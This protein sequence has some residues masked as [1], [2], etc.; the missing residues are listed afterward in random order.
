VIG[1]NLQLLEKDLPRDERIQRRMQ[2][3]HEAVLRGSTLASQLLSFARRQALAPKVINLGRVV[4]G[5]D[6]MLRRALSE[7]VEIETVIAGGLWNAHVDPTQVETAILNL[8]VN[9][10][11][12]MA[13]RGRL[14]IEAGNARLD[15]S[16]AVQHAEVVPGQYVMV[17]VTDTGC[18]MP[19]EVAEQVFDPFF[20]TKPEGQGTGLGLSMVHGFVKQ[21]GGHV[22]VYS[23]VGQGTTIRIYLPRSRDKE[24]APVDVATG[25]ITGGSEVVLV[26]E[27][28]DDVRTTTCEMLIDLG[29]RVLRARDAD[30]GMAIIDSGAVIDLL[31][32]DVVMP[33][34]LNSR[35]L[36]RKAQQKLPGLPILFT[37]GYTDN[38]IVHAGRLDHGVELLSKPFTREELAQK[39]RLLLDRTSSTAPEQII[40]A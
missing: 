34:Q 25:A 7:A 29:Y 39:L 15:D 22:K 9:A 8:A 33:G 32:T 18:G 36:G 5:M 3:A 10:R 6:D 35:D 28:D 26:V 17:A 12:A 14:T 2:N 1:G 4:R 19:K 38:A 24:D 13:G 21:S 11:D 31:F 16:Y 40:T 23:E 30:S 27:D 37:S 20:T